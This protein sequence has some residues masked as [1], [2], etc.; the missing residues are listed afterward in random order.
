MFLQNAGIHLTDRMFHSAEYR[1]MNI[2]CH[3]NLKSCI[4]SPP[5]IY[6]PIFRLEH[7]LHLSCNYV[8]KM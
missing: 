6:L 3:K 7:H 4:F 8:V 1:N 2:H 5:V